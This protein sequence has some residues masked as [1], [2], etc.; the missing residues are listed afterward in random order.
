MS[1]I[2]VHVVEEGR[3]TVSLWGRVMVASDT[4]EAAVAGAEVMI[5]DGPAKFH[6]KL[7]VRKAA[8]PDWHRQ[9]ERFDRTRSR[10]DGTFFFVNLPPVDP[11]V[12]QPYKLTAW[13]DHLGTRVADQAT[14]T[15]PVHPVSL[16]V[17]VTELELTATSVKGQVVDK[18]D[19]KSPVANAT[20][21]VEQPGFRPRFSRPVVTGADGRF[22]VDKLSPEANAIVSVLPPPG[23]PILDLVDVSI[24]GTVKRKQGSN[25]APGAIVTLNQAGS[26]RVVKAGANA[27]FVLNGLLAE[28]SAVMTLE[29][30]AGVAKLELSG[31]SITGRIVFKGSGDPVPG[32]RVRLLQAPLQEATTDP[33]G[34]FTLNNLMAGAD[35]AVSIQPAKLVFTATSIVGKV[36]SAAGAGKPVVKATVRVEQDGL[37]RETKTDD[38][39][40]YRLTGLLADSETAT[41]SEAT[42]LVSADKFQPFAG[43]PNVPLRRGLTATFDIS[44]QPV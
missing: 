8:K 40:R 32:S 23:R 19:N 43:K 42:I 37:S 30:E 31:A 29:P 36:V 9:S 2:H 26:V 17:A 27:A 14:D 21:R 35:F 5:V 25:P 39:G 10:Q 16:G 7:K 1:P 15:V 24:Q 4:G 28:A 34:S 41:A 38:E 6:D 11:A 13:A 33:A 22:S 12:D 20:V 18:K 3:Q 44:L